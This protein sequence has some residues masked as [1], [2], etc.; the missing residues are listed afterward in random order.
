MLEL[1]VSHG[2]YLGIIVFLILTGC[3]L[4]IPEE[5]PIV[6]VG[7]LSAQGTMVPALAFVSCL[8]GAL[9]GDCVVYAIGYHFGHNLLKDHPKFARFLHAEREAKFEEM[10]N[11]HGLKVL[12]LARFMIGVR[13]PVYLSAG[14]LRVSFRKFLL[15]DLLCATVV[16][17]LFFGLSYAFG[18]QIVSSLRNAEIWLTVTVLVVLGVGAVYIFWRRRN[19]LRQAVHAEEIQ[20]SLDRDK[21]SVK[22]PERTLA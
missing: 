14:I 17:S 12:F 3:G 11:R 10:I 20:K 5:V 2:S 13:S 22:S 4:P 8:V 15:T 9:I 7:V 21:R 16:V 1:L 19:R 18:E 6:M